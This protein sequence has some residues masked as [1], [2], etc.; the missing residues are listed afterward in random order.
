[1]KFAPRVELSPRGEL[2]LLA[3]MFTS[4]MVN[5]LYVLYCYE[6]GGANKGSLPLWGQLNPWGSKFA[7]GARLKTGLSTVP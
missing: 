7:L 1:M 6:N 2:F 5:T 3:E 4:G